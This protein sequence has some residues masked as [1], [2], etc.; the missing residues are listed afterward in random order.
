VW[1]RGPFGQKFS[2]KKNCGL[3]LVYQ[4]ELANRL[5]LV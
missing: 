3:E 5:E 2:G 4:L 1:K